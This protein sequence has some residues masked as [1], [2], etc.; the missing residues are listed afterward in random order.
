MKEANFANFIGRF[1]FLNAI[2][3]LS[4]MEFRKED[5]DKLS[6]EDCNSIFVNGSINIQ[7]LQ[8]ILKY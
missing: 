2:H 8:D 5:M 6:S 4:G 7:Y 1:G 3:K